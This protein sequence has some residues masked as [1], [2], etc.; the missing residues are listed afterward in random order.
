MSRSE[1]NTRPA[2]NPAGAGLRHGARWREV[3]TVYSREMRAAMRERTIVV[4]SILLPIFLYPLILWIAF[5]VMAYVQGRTSGAVANIAVNAWPR[6]HP[7][8]LRLFELQPDLK[9]LSSPGDE[10]AEL[11]LRN[12]RLDVYLRFSTN[13]GAKMIGEESSDRTRTAATYQA[14]LLFNEA[15]PRSIEARSQVNGIIADYRQKWLRREALRLGATPAEWQQFAVVTRNI[16]S[17]K[18]V[19]A[20]VLGLLAPILFVVMVAMGCFHPAVDATAGE[21]ER[22]TWETLMSTAAQRTSIIVAK[23]LYVASLGAIAGGLNLLALAAT[24]KP[25]FAPLLSQTGAD[26]EFTIPVAA[27]P[28]LLLAALLLAGFV[29]AGMML[30]AAFARTF[31]EGQAMITPFYLVILLPIMFLQTPGLQFTSLLALVPVVNV[32]LMARS[33]VMGAFPLREITITLLVS[34]TLI[35]ACLKVAA[36]VLKF[37]DV[38]IGSYNGSFLR[39]LRKRLVGSKSPAPLNTSQK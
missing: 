12:G 37:E 10:Q 24:A 14:A 18:Q 35:A 27:A 8:L 36:F 26:L 16:A 13:S 11:M 21:R 1:S 28:V 22:N 32:T 39:F 25:V 33:A 20:F 34:G 31:K 15:R 5:T 30:F 23:Y 4:N 6:E 29:A 2:T 3:W 7:G 38:M 9:L 17:G 19:G